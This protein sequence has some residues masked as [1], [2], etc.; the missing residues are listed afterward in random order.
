MRGGA[1][2]NQSCA[3]T[4]RLVITAPPGDRS[5]M[6]DVPATLDPILLLRAIPED[7]YYTHMAQ[8]IIA[9][10]QYVAERTGIEQLGYPT[11]IRP[12]RS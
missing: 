7:V 3:M 8:D 4:L 5:L 12:G 9:R 6:L 10:P 11:D 1:L 2:L